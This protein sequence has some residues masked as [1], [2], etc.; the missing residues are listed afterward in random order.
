MFAGPSKQ[1]TYLAARGVASFAMQI[2]MLRSDLP[3]KEEVIKQM[4]AEGK[5]T[6]MNEWVEGAAYFVVKQKM[7]FVRKN[8]YLAALEGYLIEMGMASYEAK[9]LKNEIGGIA[10]LIARQ[11]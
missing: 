10:D 1:D 11:R 2:R 5:P 6:T 8:Q 4:R 3:G 7:G 9:A